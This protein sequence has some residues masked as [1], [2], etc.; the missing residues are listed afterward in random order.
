MYPI[1][2]K[3]Y[4]STEHSIIEISPNDAVRKENHLWV[5][6]HLQNAAKKERKYKEIKEGDTIRVSIKK[7]KF[8]KGHEPNWSTTRHKV[9]DVKGNQYFIPSVNKSKLFLRHEI[10]KV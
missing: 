2:L 7:G 6:W 10:L 3:K 1:Q 8:A 5:N 9:V 4:N